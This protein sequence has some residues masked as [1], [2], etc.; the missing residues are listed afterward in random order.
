MGRTCCIKR[1]Q[2]IK[3]TKG[4]SKRDIEDRGKQLHKAKAP[5]DKKSQSGI[6]QKVNFSILPR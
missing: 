3:L 6:T 4:G 5:Q 1:I 2:I